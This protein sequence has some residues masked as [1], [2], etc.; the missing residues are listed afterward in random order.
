M[1]IPPNAKAMYDSIAIW[2]RCV[3]NRMLRCILLQDPAMFERVHKQVGPNSST[4]VR[5][6]PLLQKKPRKRRRHA[7][8]P[9]LSLSSLAV[10]ARQVITSALFPFL[11]LAAH[12]R[13]AR[14]SRAML[15]TAGI[16]RPACLCIRPETWKKQISMRATTTD[17]DLER[18][19]RIARP[20]ALELRW[21]ESISDMGI[22]CLQSMSLTSLDLWGC[23][24]MTDV[25]LSHLQHMALQRL[26]LHACTMLSDD[27]LAHLKHMPL[28]YL[29]LTGRPTF[30]DKGIAHLQ[31]LSS[32]EELDMTD[33]LVTDRGLAFLKHLSLCQLDLYKCDLITD[34]GLAHLKDMRLRTLDLRQC[35][36]ITDNGLLHLQSMPLTTLKLSGGRITDGGLIHLKHFLLQTLDL[37]GCSRITDAGLLHLQHMPLQQLGLVSCVLLT[38]KGV[39]HFREKTTSAAI[40]IVH[41]LD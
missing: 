7:V 6:A 28:K 4:I 25:G 14:T 23:G 30:T 17:Y 35:F 3:L 21:C 12:A 26:N 9:C 32:L 19:S 8:S 40:E 31:H 1:N 15:D 41:L 33:Q 39:L 2:D 38:R 11:D 36:N 34:A 5:S 20:T 37:S 16:S 27:G 29:R 13:I 10:D 18:L 24:L 22:A